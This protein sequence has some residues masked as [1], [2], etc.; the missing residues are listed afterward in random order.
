VKNPVQRHIG[1]KTKMRPRMRPTLPDEWTSRAFPKKA[2]ACCQPQ[3][4]ATGPKGEMD[5]VLRL[6][7][8]NGV[9]PPWPPPY[10]EKKTITLRPGVQRLVHSVSLPSTSPNA[11]CVDDCQSVEQAIQFLDRRAGLHYD[12]GMKRMHRFASGDG[13]GSWTGLHASSA[14]PVWPD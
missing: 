7:P 5:L 11:M 1:S 3:V 14:L 2:C 6:T 10:N 12:A 13:C 4:R 8:A 9:R